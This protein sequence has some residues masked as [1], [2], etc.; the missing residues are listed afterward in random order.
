MAIPHLSR[1]AVLV[2]VLGLGCGIVISEGRWWSDPQS[3]APPAPARAEGLVAAA[4]RLAAERDE[5]SDRILARLKAQP[6]PDREKAAH[7]RALGRLRSPAAIDY[8]LANHTFW[9]LPEDPMNAITLG[10]MPCVEALAA[11]GAAALPRVVEAYLTWPKE[12]E[13]QVLL[14]VFSG[15]PERSR[16]AYVYA[17]GYLF[18]NKKDPLLREKV[19]DL[20]WKL[21][22]SLPG[23]DLP[24]PPPWM[25][26]FLY[27]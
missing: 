1:R 10:E 27:D 17:Q 23:G 13:P 15:N 4:D 5:L 2:F 24:L 14:G 12:R 7:V 9:L 26:P 3:S 11:I 6:M 18:A 16:V 19:Y 25:S 20:Y 21:E 8:L 22:R